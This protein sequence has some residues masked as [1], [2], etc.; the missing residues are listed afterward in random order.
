MNEDEFRNGTKDRAGEVSFIK[1]DSAENELQLL[2]VG[3]LQSIGEVLTLGARK[4]APGNWRNIDKRSRYFGAMLR[5]AFAWWR[6]EDKDPETG[7][8]HL[9]HLGCCALFLLECE[10]DSLG[11]DDRPRPTMKR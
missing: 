11:E 6:G 7:L 10:I 1:A 2:P 4:Y 8:S 3:A 5:H 9:A